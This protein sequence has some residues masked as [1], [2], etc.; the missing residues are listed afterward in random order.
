MEIKPSNP[1]DIAPARMMAGVFG[2]IFGGIGLTVLGFLWLTP[3]DEWDAPPLVFRIFGS[4][5]AL[6]FVA[7]GGGVFVRQAFLQKSAPLGLVLPTPSVPVAGAAGPGAYHCP[8]CAASLA[9]NAE[10]SPS[11]DVKCAFCHSWFNVRQQK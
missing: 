6:G 4:F 11:G 2:F 7:M 8:N 3:F 1:I 10:V 5:V 9:A